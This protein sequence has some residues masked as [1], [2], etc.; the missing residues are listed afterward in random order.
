MVPGSL[1][2]MLTMAVATVIVLVASSTRSMSSSSPHERRPPPSEDVEGVV[3]GPGD[4]L[5]PLTD[6]GVTAPGRPFVDDDGVRGEAADQR[7]DVP[8]VGGGEVPGD[9]RWQRVGHGALLQRRLPVVP[10]FG[11]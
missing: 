1:V 11:P 2:H 6:L 4:V 5:P 10:H 7:V 3:V 8:V 9:D